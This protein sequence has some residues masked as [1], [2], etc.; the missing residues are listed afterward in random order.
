[1]HN[2]KLQKL[3]ILNYKKFIFSPFF[4]LELKDFIL[5]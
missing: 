3:A 4:M 2:F 1:M 5:I